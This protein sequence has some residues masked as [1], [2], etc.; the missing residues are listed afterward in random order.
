MARWINQDWMPSP[1]SDVFIG[2]GGANIIDAQEGSDVLLGD[3]SLAGFF[4]DFASRTDWT[5]GSSIATA[6]NL[7]SP[8]LTWITGENP[9]LFDNGVTPYVSLSFNVDGFQSEYLSIH[10]NA[11]QTLT[12]DVDYSGLYSTSV[13]SIVDVTTFG[14]TVVAHNDDGG[15]LGGL[16]SISDLD[17]FVTFTASVD[18]TYYIHLYP[19]GS[20]TFAA[21]TG[22]ILTVS[23]TGH[24]STPSV[25]SGA[26]Q[27]TGGLG[28]D[29][30]GGGPGND[31]IA[32][33]DGNDRL[34]GGT[35]DDT[36]E[37]GPGVDIIDGGA[38]NDI[39][40][41]GDNG[42][43]LTGGNGSDTFVGT[44]ASLNNDYIADFTPGDRII[45]TDASFAGFNVS[46]TGNALTY[47]GGVLNLGAVP[48]GRIVASPAVGTGLKLT[49]MYSVVMQAGDFNG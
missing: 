16:G 13:D 32:G 49:V 43:Y 10:M 6:L 45:L 17:P 39:I 7:D 31:Q 47:S 9:L 40:S 29:Q 14:A 38:G 5:G 11:G 12:V 19:Y 22:Y 46:V 30:I 25:V 35:G 1:T 37:G 27:L 18:G 20:A 36:I 24:S 44:R 21:N 2:M 33:N 4:Q 15:T 26:D 23:L 3:L 48:H 34:M 41:P 28:D 8:S 42:D